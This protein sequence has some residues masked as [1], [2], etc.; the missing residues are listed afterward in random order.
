MVQLSHPCMTT[1]KTIVLSIQTFVSK[2]MSLLFSMLFRFAIAFVPRSK[3]L[4]ISW[5]QSAAQENTSTFSPSVSLDVIGPDDM[6]FVF[7]MFNFKPA[8]SLSCFILIKRLFSSSSLSTIRVV[9]SVYLRLLI[10][11]PAILIL[12]YDSSS[13][14]FHIMYSAYKSLTYHQW[15]I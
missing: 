14:A 4:L 8:F 7:W 12:A 11:L 5:P 9:S 15:L 13:L 1:G 3:G 2:V 10:F 6:I